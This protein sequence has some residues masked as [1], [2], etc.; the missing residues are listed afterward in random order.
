MVQPSHLSDQEL[1]LA[2]DGELS[3]QHSA[4][5]G[6]HLDSCV[7][8]RER[9]RHAETALADFIQLQRRESDAILPSISGPR[10]L[11]KARLAA[12]ASQPETS[13]GN[14][15]PWRLPRFANRYAWAASGLFFLVTLGVGL[16]QWSTARVEAAAAPKPRLTPGATV[17]LTK[18]DVCHEGS[19]PRISTVPPS[20]K[21]QVFEEYGIANPRPDAYEVDYLITPELGGATNIRNLWPQPYY[22][23]TWHAGVKDQL[24]ERLHAMVCNGELDLATAQHEIATNWIAA[25]KKYFHTQTPSRAPPASPQPGANSGR[26][27]TVGGFE[28]AGTCAGRSAFPN[29]S[30]VPLEPS[31]VAFLILRRSQGYG[32][33]FAFQGSARRS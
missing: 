13:A 17:P 28:A 30:R 33:V 27:R 31:S 3:S 10:A 2:L 5:L 22:N 14:R 9:M 7:E 4:E 20:L 18:A 23:T 11:L 24:E 16:L 26:T 15:I 19:L 25:Y 12:I 1:A 6:E 29:R 21:R 32:Y 8:C